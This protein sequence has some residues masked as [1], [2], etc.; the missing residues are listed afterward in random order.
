M[1]GDG[2]ISQE[3]IL[4]ENCSNIVASNYLLIDGG[5]KIDISTGK[6]ATYH[7][8]GFNRGENEEIIVDNVQLEYK[9]TYA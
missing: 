4:E 1:S 6:I 3:D 5:D 8:I 7:I 9:Y 2:L